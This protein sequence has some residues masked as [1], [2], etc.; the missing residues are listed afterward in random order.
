MMLSFF[1]DRDINNV[2]ASEWQHVKQWADD[3]LI[4]LYTKAKGINTMPVDWV[5]AN[6]VVLVML[7]PP[8]DLKEL[9]DHEGDW[10]DQEQPLINV[11]AGSGPSPSTTSLAAWSNTLPMMP[12]RSSSKRKR[13]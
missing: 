4:Y 3:Q 7:I 9:M 13:S 8:Q 10:I 11:V 12:S 2:F 1:A 5:N 6:W